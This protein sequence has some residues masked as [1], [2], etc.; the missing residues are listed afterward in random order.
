MAR[1]PIGPGID[2][3]P[4]A[5]I[6]TDP[7]AFVTWFTTIYLKRWA[8]NADPRNGI[9]GN[10]VQITGTINTPVGIG[11]G[12]NSITSAELRKSA[13]DSVI[14][15]PTGVIANVQD[16]VATADG[17]F[18][19]RAGGALVWGPVVPTITTADSI[20]GLG[21]A[22]SPLELVGDAAVPGNSLYYGTDIS[23]NKGFHPFSGSSIVTLT[24]TGGAT[25]VYNVPATATAVA[26][27][28]HGGGGGGASGQHLGTSGNQLGGGA[29]GGGGISYAL[30]RAADLGA[31]VSVTFSNAATAGNGGAPV[32]ATAQ[33][34]TGVAG[35][36]VSFGGKLLASGGNPGLG[37][38][39][40]G[41]AGAGGS[42]NIATGTAGGGGTSGAAGINGT[43]QSTATLTG[44]CY[45]N[46]GGGGGG[47]NSGVATFVG[48][49]GG[50]GTAFIA[51]TG[52]LGGGGGGGGGASGAAGSGSSPASGGGGGGGTNTTANGGNGGG[53]GNYGA[54]GGGGGSAYTT[55]TQSGGGGNGGP[56]ACIIIAW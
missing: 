42:G 16:I 2:S 35:S 55:A 10:A 29:G 14:G 18:L 8:A 27:I 53:G 33:G 54:G 48:G 51:L 26:V 41:V 39:S 12:P 30:F 4:T 20:T 34:T 7:Q 36:N 31:S 49:N 11:I 6:P 40:T 43:A 24:S 22:A 38:A 9:P 56:A 44:S 15:N 45:G 32:T 50:N 23:G 13:A 3:I 28:L 5:T 52:G 1:I 21:S 37:G 25:Q 19:Q 17:Q 46:T 47:G